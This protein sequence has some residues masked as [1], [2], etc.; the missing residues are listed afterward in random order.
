MALYDTTAL[1][2]AIIG[3]EKVTT[4]RKSATRT[5][6]KFLRT[7]FKAREVAT[8]GKG[9]RYAI[10]LKAAELRSMKKRFADWAAAEAKA[11][12]ERRELL[13]AKVAPKTAGEQAADE[14]PEVV[15][16]APEDAPE[17]IEGPSDE[18]LAEMLADLDDEATEV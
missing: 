9:G 11:Q 14:A 12:A 10:E 15:E 7:D 8:P 18:E 6:R 1:A 3:E 5:L 2:L 4:N 17:V 13:A 16:D